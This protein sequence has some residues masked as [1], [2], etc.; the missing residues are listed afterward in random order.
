VKRLGVFVSGILLGVGLAFIIGWILFPI[1][2]YDE[3]PTSMRKDYRDEYIRL[4]ALAYQADANLQTATDRLRGL[5]TESPT[6]PLV[7][8]TLRWINEGRSQTLI[9][10]LA[11]LAHD[12]QVD[13]PAMLPY[14]SED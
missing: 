11:I 13:T 14:L 1:V 5:D 7:E 3:S 8:L 4:T 6:T 2:R 10:P 12:L 9:A